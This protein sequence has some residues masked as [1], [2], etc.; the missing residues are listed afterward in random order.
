MTTPSAASRIEVWVWI[1]IYGGL[2]V[3][4][5]GLSTLR[6]DAAIGWVLIAIGS[7]ATLIGGVLVWVRSRMKETQQ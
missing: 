5:L 2:I 4:G 6:S 7:V 3:F 1:L